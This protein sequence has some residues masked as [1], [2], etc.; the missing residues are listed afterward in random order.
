M[1][2]N[3]VYRAELKKHLQV[4][5]TPT[6][7]MKFRLSEIGDSDDIEVRWAVHAGFISF[8]NSGSSP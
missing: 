8:C 3:S 4:F 5:L 6:I 2:I 1:L 7:T